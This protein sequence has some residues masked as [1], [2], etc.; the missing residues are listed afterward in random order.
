MRLPSL[1]TILHNQVGNITEVAIAFNSWIFD[2]NLNLRYFR[3]VL[4]SWTYMP[5]SDPVSGYFVKIIIFEGMQFWG[6]IGIGVQC[7]LACGRPPLLQP[8]IRREEEQGAWGGLDE[9]R[10]REGNLLHRCPPWP[11]LPTAHSAFAQIPR[12]SILLTI[13]TFSC[14]TI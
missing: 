6:K 10:S 11:T 12:H 8:S 4:C 14:K 1:P 2:L 7:M 3:Q 9:G 5:E 13:C